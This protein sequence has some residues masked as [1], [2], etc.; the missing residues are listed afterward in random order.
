[1]KVV[2]ISCFSDKSGFNRGNFIYE[3]FKKKK[4]DTFL[5]YSEFHH[6]SKTLIKE[7]D[8]FWIPVRSL[9]YEKNV[10]IKR[11]LAHVFFGMKAAKLLKKLNPDI[12]YM[13][14]PPNSVTRFAFKVSKKINARIIIDIVD[15]WPESF[16]TS[17]KVKKL[18]SPMLNYWR[19]YRDD[20][21][22]S[23]NALM[24]ECSLYKEFLENTNVKNENSYVIPLAKNYIDNSNP[25]FM[26][27]MNDTLNIC[28]LGSI[29]L[30]IDIEQITKILKGLQVMRKVKLHIIG[31]GD[32]KNYFLKELM[33]NNIE[34]IDYGIV[35]NEIDKNRIMSFCDFGINLYRENTVIGLTYK[36]ID[37]FSAGLPIINSI[38]GDSWDLVENCG[39]GVNCFRDNCQASIT[40]LSSLNAEK[41]SLMKQ[42]AF[43]VY[44][45]NFENRVVEGKLDE[46][47]NSILPEK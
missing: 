30:L 21:L 12:V 25:D 10:S 17:N 15:L 38:K 29:N 9:K 39:I 20:K 33:Q 32:N 19:K 47:L 41:I 2:V 43:E 45:E 26:S 31:S 5:I 35:Y 46:M 36:S 34:F 40:V 3:Y 18:L 6:T 37:Y 8:E 14:V 24:F 44:L 42:K 11:L 23:A 16:P 1:M 22:G 4:F 28:Y 13:A 27:C 7:D